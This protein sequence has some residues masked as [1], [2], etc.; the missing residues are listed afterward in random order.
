MQV[1]GLPCSGD[2]AAGVGRERE[3]KVEPSVTS[4]KLQLQ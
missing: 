3:L 4:T 2:A 1:D